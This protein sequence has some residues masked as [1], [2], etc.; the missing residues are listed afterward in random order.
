MESWPLE[1]PIPGKNK[2]PV[3]EGNLGMTQSMRASAVIFPTKIATWQ[4]CGRRR[5][6]AGHALANVPA[7]RLKQILPRLHAMLKRAP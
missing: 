3:P 5:P 4:G 2:P 7:E 6:Q 1:I